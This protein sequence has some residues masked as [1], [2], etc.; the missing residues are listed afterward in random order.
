MKRTRKTGQLSLVIST[1]N[2]GRMPSVV[3]ADDV[4][5]I[6]GLQRSQAVSVL[7]NAAK[8]TNIFSK[9]GRDQFGRNTFKV[10]VIAASE[11]Q[12]RT[13]PLAKGPLVASMRNQ[14]A[15]R[16]VSEATPHLNPIDDLLDAMAKAEPIL[17]KMSEA[18]AA[19]KKLGAV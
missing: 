3:T 16:K 15:A 4:A 19:M 8:R 17:K 2:E 12:A 9:E 13:G 10:N 5:A 1:I 7:D 6:T 11:Y 18:Y 14:R